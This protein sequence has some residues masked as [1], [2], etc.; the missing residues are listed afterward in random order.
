MATIL[1]SLKSLDNRE[2]MNEIFTKSLDLWYM[3]PSL[4]LLLSTRRPVRFEARTAVNGYGYGST[5]AALLSTLVLSIH[6]LTAMIYVVYSIWFAKATSSSWELITELVA[7]AMDYKPSSTM[8]N[9][10]AGIATLRAI[11]QP[12]RMGVSADHLQMVFEDR[13]GVDKISRN[14][15]YG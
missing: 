7:W 8:R 4:K 10:G 3:R 1:G 12:V 11:K 9:T 6:S 2:W 13:E 14:K 15:L 5:T